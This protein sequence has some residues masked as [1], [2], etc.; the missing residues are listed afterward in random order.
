MDNVSV[1][2]SR[3]GLVP[4]DHEDNLSAP[5]PGAEKPRGSSDSKIGTLYVNG[6][7][8]DVDRSNRN[9][10]V[11]RSIPVE[12]F[13]L[14]HITHGFFPFAKLV[15]RS[16]QQCW[17]DLSDLIT[18]LVGI[19]ISSQDQNSP[20]LLATGKVP[21]NQSAENVQKKLRILD[22]AHAKRA[23]FIKLLVLSQ[24]SR[25][26]ADVSKLIDLQG[27]IRTR[28][29]AYSGAIQLVGD[30]KRDLVRA[31]VATPDLKTALEVLSK[32][33]V[34]AMPDL[35][36]RP[37]KPL[38]PRN[39]LKKLRK[40][41]RIIGVRLALHDTFP[42]P[43]RTYHVHD[44]RVTFIVPEEFEV[45]LSIAEE[46]KTS[47]FFFVDIRFLFTPSSPVP[48]G[49][50]FNELDIK[51]NNTLR[52]SGLWGCFDLL[53]SLV[54]TNKIN[55]LFKQA[56]D[57]ARGLWSDALHVEL[58]HR[59]L[60]IQYWTSRPGPKSWFEIGIKSG[61]KKASY[62]QD[63]L[64]Q[65][66]FLGLRWIRGGQE[67]DSSDIVFDTGTL[68]VE[69]IL[70]SV[71]AIHISHILS[72]AYAKLNE[73]RLF[74]TRVLSLR[75][76]LSGIEPGDC[77]LDV[78]LTA[79]RQLRV[80]IEPMSGAS[81]L[82]S[83]P[84]VLDRP[85]TER[86]PERSLADDV[87]TRISRVRCI[88]A[89]EEIESNAKMLG[90]E[91]V[92]PRE[93]KLDIRKIFPSNVLRFSFFSHR[94]W[95]RNWIAAATSSMD[96]DNLWAV[97]LRPL[98][99]T[100]NDLALGA[101][102]RESTV[103][104]WA[105]IISNTF[106]TPQQQLNYASCADLGHCLSGILA[107]YANARYLGEL[108][109]INFYPPLQKLQLDSDLQVP[110]IF[111]RYEVG[112]LPSSL[113]IA[114]PMGLKRKTFVK[115]TIRLAFLG[116]D[117]N[118]KLAILVAYGHLLVSGKSLTSLNSKLDHS[119]VFQPTGSGF[120]IR[121]LAPAGRSIIVN[122][123]ERLQRLECVLSILEILQRKR[124]APLSLSLSKIAFAYGSERDLS[125]SISIKVLGPSS[126]KNIDAVD[127]VSK[128][129]S[130]FHLH[131]DINFDNPN[132]HRRIQESLT[133]I[134]NNDY[135]DASLESVLD[136]LSVTLPLL[137]VFDRIT[138][139]TSLEEPLKVQVTVRN[140]KTF[141]ISYPG[142]KCQMQLT[143]GR[144]LNRAN[145][146]L[147]DV[148]DPQD[149]L[150]HSHITAKLREMLY[151]SKGDGWRGLG[152]GAV[153]EV[154]GVCNLVSE[155]HKCLTDTQSNPD[156]AAPDN[157]PNSASKVQPAEAGRTGHGG[158][159][160]VTTVQQSPR[161]SK[162]TNIITID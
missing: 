146:T 3:Q 83:T 42:I 138:T 113:R 46:S 49:R 26:A 66:P 134:L 148:S 76:E 54:L 137:Q 10:Q 98:V 19:Q 133:S 31:Q 144:H 41:N 84:T 158:R 79:S 150:S 27:F 96:S 5:I 97:Q 52:D 122:L 91:P 123:L 94:L 68:S 119:L 23:E 20:S 103:L 45:D 121:M 64:G 59:T 72:S 37:P 139:N 125:A 12:P 99:T 53:H 50:F 29:Q 89:M 131:L 11:A 32:G 7:L 118:S 69:N 159:V 8:K 130:L 43:F 4:H 105:Q 162:S 56:T 80:S 128:P 140:A 108:Q 93:F 112:K 153:A 106:L 18:E 78:Q 1:D 92:N 115:E 22:F 81:V 109:R 9:S 67:V 85:E 36:Y 57:L 149:R 132:P 14:T 2:G 101:G 39:A 161:G 38:T 88:A 75:A 47:Q 63:R 107:I 73:M 95:E 110:S 48:K 143:L 114:L 157:Q 82:S 16:V 155:L 74:S 60:V 24:W 117:P 120:A 151:N 154:D 70:R 135:S 30:M 160:E 156:T 44:G 145:W 55:I 136:L 127:L 100:V 58:L 142:T 124:I 90:L 104:Q 77:H 141:R 13:Q 87:V 35:G 17:N 86:N 28:H 6:G 129:H 21:G 51:V 33:K 62:G 147:K 152:N 126:S 65:V 15:N 61:H 71:I 102:A 111:L 40:I 116:V 25:K 34:E